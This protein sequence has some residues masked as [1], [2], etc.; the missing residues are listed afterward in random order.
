MKKL[1]LRKQFLF[2]KIILN[3]KYILIL[4]SYIIILIKSK[5]EFNFFKTYFKVIFIY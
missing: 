5:N 4:I 2:E 1:Y 3:L